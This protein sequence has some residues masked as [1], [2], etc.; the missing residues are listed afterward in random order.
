MWRDFRSLAK[1]QATLAL[2]RSCRIS[3]IDFLVRHSSS[4]A[5][6]SLGVAGDSILPHLSRVT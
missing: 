4:R 1:F 6:L 3:L 2:S 5:A